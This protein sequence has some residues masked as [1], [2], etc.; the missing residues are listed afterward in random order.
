MAVVLVVEPI[1]HSLVSQ[2]ISQLTVA[3]CKRVGQTGQL[4][5][6]RLSF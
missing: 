5:V 3:W 2:A 6:L 1:L 4:I